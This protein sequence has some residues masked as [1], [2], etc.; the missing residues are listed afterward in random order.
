MSTNKTVT[1]LGAQWQSKSECGDSVMIH[2][3]VDGSEAGHVYCPCY[4][5]LSDI[6]AGTT[7]DLEI[8]G[9]VGVDEISME[10]FNSAIENTGVN[11]SKIKDAVKGIF[12][13]EW[14]DDSDLPEIYCVQMDT[15]TVVDGVAI[16]TKSLKY[17]L[18]GDM[19]LP[20]LPV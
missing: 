19:W 13:S 11:G 17:R 18:S 10:Y 16:G 9:W 15:I 14:Y 2:V 7:E 6:I 12:G 8:G 4:S 3:F 5:D 1:L 20:V